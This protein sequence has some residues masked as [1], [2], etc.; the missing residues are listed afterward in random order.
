MTT[1]LSPALVQSLITTTDAA[2]LAGVSVAAISNWRDRGYLTPA[3]YL[4][5]VHG[6]RQRPLYRWIDVAKAE[7]ATRARARRT[8]PT[9]A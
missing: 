9:A 2:N 5:A 1:G 7:H 6:K 4:P 8:Y 3:A